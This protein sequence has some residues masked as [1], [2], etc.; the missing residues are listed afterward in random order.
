MVFRQGLSINFA[1]PLC[2]G[3]VRVKALL[4]ANKQCAELTQDVFVPPIKNGPESSKMVLR[5]VVQRCG[6]YSVGIRSGFGISLSYTS[7][8]LSDKKERLQ[9][10]KVMPKTSGVCCSND[11]V[12]LD[13]GS[14]LHLKEKLILACS[15]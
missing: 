10:K 13:P 3:V 4:H 7:M 5:L 1:I 15:D 8:L 14:Q 12:V 6:P 9:L 11:A 2:L